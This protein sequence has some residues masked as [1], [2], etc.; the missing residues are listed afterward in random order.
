M[1]HRELDVRRAQPQEDLA[2]AAEL[3]ELGEDQPDR[4][5]RTRSSG[6]IS[7]RS[8]SLQQKPGGRVKRSSPRPAFASRAARP[9][10][11]SR[12][13]SYSDIVPF[14]PSEP[15]VVHQAGIVD[16][17]GVDHQGAGQGAEVDQMMPVPPVAGQ[18][19]GL[20]AVDRPHRSGADLGDQ[21]LEARP[22]HLP[23]ARTSQILVDHRH[24]HEARAAGGL[25]HL[26]LPLLAL[27]VAQN[28]AHRRLP[29]VDD[30]AAREVLSGD[31]RVHH[32]MSL[33]ASCSPQPAAS[34]PA[35][36]G[37]PGSSALP[38]DGSCC[39]GAG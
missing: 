35:S 34:P 20:D 3:A 10:C 11:R 13:S 26:V 18:P 9:R 2:A 6:S 27:E 1:H 17:F 29:D 19:R 7:I 25:G 38:A 12:P 31:L 5:A 30:G 8:S 16:P 28:L 21:S 37:A 32:R 15:P 39:P 24:R 22:G 36:R 14:N 23:G 4:L 33:P